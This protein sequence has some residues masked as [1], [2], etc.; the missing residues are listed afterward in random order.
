M[1]LS[2][3][4]NNGAQPSLLHIFGLAP[5]FRAFAI[6]L[7]SFWEM[8]VKRLS[9]ICCSFASIDEDTALKDSSKGVSLWLNNLLKRLLAIFPLLSCTMVSFSSHCTIIRGIFESV[10][11]ACFYILSTNKRVFGL[12]R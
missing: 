9:C 4:R 1:P 2:I 12:K 11:Y 3:A 10:C 5:C 8:A 6:A 7:A